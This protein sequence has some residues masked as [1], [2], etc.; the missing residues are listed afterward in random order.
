MHFDTGASVAAAAAAQLESRLLYPRRGY[1]CLQFFYYNSGAPE[2]KLSI[3]VREYD[4]VHPEGNLRLI[5]II[6]GA[7]PSTMLF[8]FVTLL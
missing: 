2:D 4:R 5:K 1:Q 3:W 7:D 6:D 8:F